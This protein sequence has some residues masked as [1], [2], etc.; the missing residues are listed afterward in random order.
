MEVIRLQEKFDQRE[1]LLRQAGPVVISF[2]PVLLPL[3]FLPP[4]R[5][6]IDFSPSVRSPVRHFDVRNAV[7]TI[8]RLVGLQIAR[9]MRCICRFL[10]SRS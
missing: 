9:G 6:R 10:M 1:P 3:A 7:V 8:H 4:L 2:A 5:A